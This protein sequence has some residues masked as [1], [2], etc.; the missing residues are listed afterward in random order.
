M[1]NSHHIRNN[2]YSTAHHYRY[3]LV[4]FLSLTF[5]ISIDHEGDIDNEL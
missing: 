4:D 1:D 2:P 3:R 5:C